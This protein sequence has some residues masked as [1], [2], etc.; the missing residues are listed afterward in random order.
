M[1]IPDRINARWI[2]TL[3]DKQLITAEAQLHKV[4]RAQEQTEKVRKGA[5]YMLLHGPATLVTAWQRWLLVNNETRSRGLMA[6]RR[7]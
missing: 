3:N 6:V 4:F 2:A 1:T 7:A 5:Q